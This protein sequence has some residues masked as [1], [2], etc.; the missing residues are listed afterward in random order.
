MWHADHD[1]LERHVHAY[2]GALQKA[3]DNVQSDEAPMSRTK[4]RANGLS[5][6]RTSRSRSAP[7][8][9]ECALASSDHMTA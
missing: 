7:R 2:E 5:A 3:Y 4:R 8:R 6:D 1:T 9:R